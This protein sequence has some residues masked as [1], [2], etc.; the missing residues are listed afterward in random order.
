MVEQLK[1]K[2]KE[3]GAD[4]EG[5]LHRFMGNDALFLK[6]ILKFKDDKNYAALKDALD[7]RNYE[8]AFKA[9]HTLKG[10]SA[11]LGL[12]PIYDCASAVT[13]LL[14]G[15]E[16]SE[17]DNEKVEQEKKALEEAYKL[18]IGIIEENA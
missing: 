11:N 18:F 6:F 17:V 10:V 14:R 13:E 3:N 16:A 2:L 7:Q 1:Q 15:K 4:V 8:E 9:A 5:T 12:N